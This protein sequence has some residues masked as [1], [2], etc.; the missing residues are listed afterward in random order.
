M[1]CIQFQEVH[2]NTSVYECMCM[3][4]DGGIKGE[5]EGNRSSSAR[6]LS[7]SKKPTLQQSLQAYV[8]TQF[9]S[10][11]IIILLPE[12]I[13][14]PLQL[15]STEELGNTL[16][17]VLRKDECAEKLTSRSTKIFRCLIS[18]WSS[19]IF[20]TNSPATGSSHQSPWKIQA[21]VPVAS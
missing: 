9:S 21:R 20:Q 10:C 8:H 19:M 14:L 11:D 3:Y 18:L 16:I 7:N 4:A 5:V 6:Y 2:E 17:P 15:L 1:N 12:N 13:K